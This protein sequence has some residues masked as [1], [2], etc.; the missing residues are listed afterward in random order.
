MKEGF[1][2]DSGQTRLALWPEGHWVLIYPVPCSKIPSDSIW[3][4]SPW[5]VTSVVWPKLRI[6]GIVDAINIFK[7][8]LA[9][10]DTSMVLGQSIFLPL[11][12]LWRIGP[13]ALFS[14]TN[15]WYELKKA[16]LAYPARLHLQF[17][18]N[19]M[20]RKTFPNIWQIRPPHPVVAKRRKMDRVWSFRIT[21]VCDRQRFF[22]ADATY[23]NITQKMSWGSATH[24]QCSFLSVL[25]LEIFFCDWP[26]TSA[27]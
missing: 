9:S 17:L 5:K 19:P 14:A 11:D 22:G 24:T 25:V 16:W 21:Y 13:P 18:D 3:S 26:S 8:E 23:C 20:P 27:V 2:R 15:S 6:W 10:C 7:Q 1:G 4:C 12:I